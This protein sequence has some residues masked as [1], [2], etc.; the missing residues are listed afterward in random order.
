MSSLAEVQ[1]AFTR[2]CFDEEPRPEDLA[3]LH[4]DAERWR[5]YRSMVRQRLFE[6]ARSGLPGT[7]EL[8]G[9]DAFDAAVGGYLAAGGPRSRFIRDVVHELV[10]H[11]LPGWVAAP[12]LPA[13]LAELV[14]YEE[15]KW[16]VGHVAIELPAADELDFEKPPVW[17]PALEIVPLRHRVDKD[18][19]HPAALDQ[20]C[21][22]LVYRKPDG[23][24][25]FTYVVN[26]IGG[27]LV[28][29]WRA[30]GSCADGAR[31]VLAELGREPDARFIDGM[32]G[33]LAELV[34]QQIVLG[35]A[36]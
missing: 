7:A 31:R 3:V 26:D 17:N 35:S 2:V 11:A 8:L 19:I 29:A 13:H 1:R 33:V 18:P 15:A 27:R 16:R 10:E 12:S 21:S 24:R 32:A 14:R 30:G 9:A 6:M 36:R 4:G 28:S 34:E 20:P 25:I 22:A 23:P 5:M